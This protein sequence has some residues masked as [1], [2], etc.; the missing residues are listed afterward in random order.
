MS[1]LMKQSANNG[2][3]RELKKHKASYAFLA[4]FTAIFLVF[5]IVPITI[6]IFYSFTAFNI[7]N[8]PKFVWFENYR[9]LFLEDEIFLIAIKNTLVFAAISGPVGYM[10]SFVM[11]WLINE[12]TPKCRSVVT[13]MFYAPALASGTAIFKFIFSGDRLGLLNAYLLELNIITDPIQWLMDPQYMKFAVIVVILWGSLGTSFLTFIAGLQ[14]TDHSLC[15]AGAVDGIKNRYQELWYI[16]LPQLKPQ[17]LFGA[18]MSITG[19]FGIGSIITQLVGFPSS[20]YAV[21]TINNHLDDYGSI[22]FEMGYACAI[23]TILFVMMLLS[24]K[25]IQKMIS[26]VGD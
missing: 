12:L 10:L 22:R 3:I 16:V 9:K 6:A 11:A 7:F 18:V 8:P 19:S 13:L 14:N 20:N 15:E 24:N 25:A 21:H 17:L 23:S 4:P 26:K 5:T 1:V 2:I